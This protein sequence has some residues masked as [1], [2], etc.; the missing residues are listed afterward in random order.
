M[1]GAP[2]T[3]LPRIPPFLLLM[4]NVSIGG[5]AIGSPA[6]IREMLEVAS[7]HEVHPWIEKRPM[8]QINQTVVDMHNSKARFRYVMVNEKHGGKL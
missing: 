7:K 3:D 8:E 1:V 6:V 2:E 5:S 4:N